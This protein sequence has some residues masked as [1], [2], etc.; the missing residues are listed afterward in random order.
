MRRRGAWTFG[1]VCAW[2]L[3]AALLAPP[4]SAHH[5]ESFQ[6]CWWLPW[7]KE[8]EGHRTVV[9]VA[10]EVVL[11]GVVKP[12]HHNYEA[13]LWRRAPCTGTW[14]L[15]KEGIEIHRWGGMVWRWETSEADANIE[16]TYGFQFR[17]PGHG[18]SNKVRIRV[19]PPGY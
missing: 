7:E 16:C 13:E 2:L 9:W 10:V 15:F 8:C 19:L 3:T 17:I 12:T 14:R 18:R 1:C 11:R 5:A 6:A 4:A